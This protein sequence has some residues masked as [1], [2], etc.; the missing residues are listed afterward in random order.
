MTYD[1]WKTMSPDDERDRWCAYGDEAPR[2][3]DHYGLTEEELAEVERDEAEYRR[4]QDRRE[5]WRKLTHPFRLP[6]YRLLARVWPRK[7]SSVLTSDE[8]DDELP[9]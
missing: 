7:A 4:K 9:F 3:E 8:L 1:Q 6:I 5:F 2:R